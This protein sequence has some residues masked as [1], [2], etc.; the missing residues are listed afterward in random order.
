MILNNFDNC[1]S[2]EKHEKELNEIN[3]QISER[4]KDYPNFEGIDFNDLGIRGIKIRGFHKQIKGYSYGGQPT[5]KY[6]FSNW[7]E[8]IDQFVTMWK[9]I[10]TPE[11]VVVAKRFFADGEKYGWD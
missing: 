4:L 1:S 7:K 6:D 5:I 9:N 10:D 3:K 11:K 2:A 8:C